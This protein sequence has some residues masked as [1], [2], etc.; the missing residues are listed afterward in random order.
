M[1]IDAGRS[2]GSSAKA[3]VDVCHVST[4]FNRRSGSG[5]RTLAIAE[6]C[7]R[8]GVSTT[9]VFGPDHDMA[10]YTGPV[11]WFVLPSFGKSLRPIRDLRAR[12]ELQDLL[13]HV[14]PR[15]V[16]THLAKAGI[17]G[18]HVASRLPDRPLVLHTVHGPTFDKSVSE[19]MRSLYRIL[20]RRAAR[21]T[22]VQV[23]VG[24][25]LRRRYRAA[26]IRP[27]GKDVVIRTG[28]VAR[29][30]GCSVQPGIDPGNPLRLV[31]V[32]RIVPMKQHDHALTLLRHLLDAGIDATLD[33]VGAALVESE[34][35][36]RDE[37]VRRV[38][39]MGLASQVRFAGH[40][41]DVHKRL[42]A[43]H[44]A[45]LVSRYEGL[46]NAVVESIQA[47]TPIV[48]YDVSGV[49]EVLGEK[50][51]RL[52]VP[53]NDIDALIDTV[54]QVN[55]NLDAIRPAVVARREELDQLYRIDVMLQAKLALYREL[56]GP[57][58]QPVEHASWHGAEN[59]TVRS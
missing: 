40:V 3:M 57:S 4:T 30:G 58:E 13:G 7:Q 31:Y 53:A 24:E 2:Q 16:H 52:V 18:R 22:Q 50:L 5:R 46:P 11:P 41:S 28:K 8:H 23:Y 10:D 6:H 51:E 38:E 36:Y 59:G 44:V 14:A 45:L 12:I 55:A 9:L 34:R 17:V 20:E 35:N 19:P 27:T 26:G 33:L 48:A 15:I 49:R 29:V 54:V 42:S 39:Q 32:A 25:E 37:L 47:G 21:H 43:A 1:S 56:L